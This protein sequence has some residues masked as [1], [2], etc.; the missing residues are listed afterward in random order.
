MPSAVSEFPLLRLHTEIFDGQQKLT[1]VLGHWACTP[2]EGTLEL[3]F[4][5]VRQPQYMS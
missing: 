5:R 2:E 4:S 1:L 3:K